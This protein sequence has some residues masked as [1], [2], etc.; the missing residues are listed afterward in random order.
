MTIEYKNALAEVDMILKIIQKNML[1][2]IPNSFLKFVEQKKS[3]SYVPNLDMKL[4]LN[5]QNLLKETRAILSLIY[6]S[7]LCDSN[8]SKKLKIDDSI[9]LRIKEIELNEKFSYKNIFKSDEVLEVGFKNKKE[10]LN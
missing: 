9:D 1:N 2:K 4:S 10:V 5:E 6:R 3:K 7:Y 8:E